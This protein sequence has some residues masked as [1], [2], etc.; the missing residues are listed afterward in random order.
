MKE[1]SECLILLLWVLFHV[2]KQL[3]FLYILLLYRNKYLFISYVFWLC[4]YYFWSVLFHIK[5]M[6]FVLSY[7]ELVMKNYF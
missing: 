4:Q 3:L 6:I 5:S 7:L 1:K 2:K